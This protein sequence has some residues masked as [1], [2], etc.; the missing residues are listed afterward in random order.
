MVT[1]MSDSPLITAVQVFFV[2]VFMPLLVGLAWWQAPQFDPY[3]MKFFTRTH[4]APTPDMPDEMRIIGW[5]MIG[6][7]ALLLWV[8]FQGI[9][10][11]VHNLRETTMILVMGI[12]IAAFGGAFFVAADAARDCIATGP[13]PSRSPEPGNHEPRP[14]Q[15]PMFR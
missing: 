12:E 14:S 11:K 6:I 5:I 3:T 15:S 7:G 13:P 2:G 10:K 9:R 4:V 1:R 8:T